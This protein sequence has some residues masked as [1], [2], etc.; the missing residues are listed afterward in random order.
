[1]KAA[2]KKRPRYCKRH[3]ALPLIEGHDEDGRAIP[4]APVSALITRYRFGEKRRKPHYVYYYDGV[5]YRAKNAVTDFA[6]DGQ[7]CAWEWCLV[8]ITKAACWDAYERQTIEDGKAA[9]VSLS[10][11]FGRAKATGLKGTTYEGL[12]LLDGTEPADYVA[13]LLDLDRPRPAGRHFR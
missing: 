2:A 4:G 5:F 10:I 3:R 13:E 7:A 12:Q 6:D 9:P 8:P 1:M 11:T